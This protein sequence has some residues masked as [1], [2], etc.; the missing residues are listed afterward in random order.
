MGLNLVNWW[1]V[2]NG[3]FLNPVL[4]SAYKVYQNFKGRV[5]EVPVLHVSE[6]TY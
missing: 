2:E 5:F 4:P 3:L 1:S 6:N